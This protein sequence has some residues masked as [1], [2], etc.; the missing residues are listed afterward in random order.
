[1]VASG[2]LAIYDNVPAVK[3]FVNGV[4]GHIAEG[5]NA[6]GHA[7]EQS[8]EAAGEAIADAGE[9]D[10]RRGRRSKGRIEILWILEKGKPND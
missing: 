7:I 4:G 5:W 8:T 2:A 6:A 1:M 9:A 3:N 10:P